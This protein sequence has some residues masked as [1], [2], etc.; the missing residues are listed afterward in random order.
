MACTMQ[1]CRHANM[2]GADSCLCVFQSNITGSAMLRG[3]R[4]LSKICK[5]GAHIQNCFLHILQTLPPWFTHDMLPLSAPNSCPHDPLST[6]LLA[7][8]LSGHAKSSAHGP[9]IWQ[10]ALG[11]KSGERYAGACTTE[12]A[13]FSARPGKVC[14][15]AHYLESNYEVVFPALLS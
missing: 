7:A 2:R 12:L 8:G 3:L 11:T 5:E 15:R 10:S 13:C 6:M 4:P 1:T 14:S 9:R